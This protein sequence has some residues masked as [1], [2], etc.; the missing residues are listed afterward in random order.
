MADIFEMVEQKSGNAGTDRIRDGL[1]LGDII[2]CP[3]DAYDTGDEQSKK[4]VYEKS[5]ITG[6]YPHL[7]SV[8]SLNGGAA[9]PI[10]TVTYVDMM[11]DRRILGR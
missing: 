6:I 8:M 4:M 3:R 11:T 2:Y 9:F 1:R 5:H 7:V 10:R